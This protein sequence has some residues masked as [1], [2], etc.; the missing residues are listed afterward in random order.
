M[1]EQELIVLV[2]ELRALPKEN[3]WIEFK[4][5]KATTNE[6]LGHYLSG[7]SN[8]ASI[9]NESFGYLVFGI[10]DETHSVIGTNFKFKSS[11]E[12]NE[13]LELWIRRNLNPS[14]KFDHFSFEYTG[15]HL[16]L[17]RIPAAIGEPTT[18]KNQ[19]FIRIGTNLTDMRKFPD[20]IRTI[21]NSQI[22]WSAQTI[23]TATIEDLDTN[24]IQLARTKYK[25]KNTNA[26]FFN[27]I[28]NWS[29][30][31]FLDKLKITINGKITNT[32]I[33]LLGKP[34]SAHFISPAVGQIT[35]KLDTQEQAYEHFNMPLFSE[36]NSILTKIRNVKYKFF[37]DNQLLATEVNKYDT[38]VILEALN[39]C[40][41]HQD[42]SKHSRIL[43]T[44]QINKLIFSNAG[45]FFDGNVEDYTAGDKTPKKYRNKWLAEAM[46][47]L[48]MIDTL[49]Y[50]I[51][52][53]YNE[54]RRRYFPLPDYTK[55]DRDNVVLEIYGHSIDENYSKLLI[56]KKD[57]L[58]LTEVILLDKIQKKQSITDEGAKLLK[59]KGL[60]EGRKPN[61]YI[62]A[63][64]AEMTGQKASYTKNKGFDK[65]YYQDLIVKHIKNHNYA[66]RIE[67]DEL[68]F[69]ILPDHKNEKQRKIYINNIISEMAGTLIEN[70]GSR[71]KSKWILLKK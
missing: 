7:I 50:G 45:S 43:L 42:Y 64:L 5:G 49:G 66:S 9:S 54:Q 40:I 10:E 60:I 55:S 56:E 19:P 20:H 27:E 48:T 12:G 53:M 63:K 11:K 46:V 51:H 4:T 31:V 26:S 24:S 2:D 34:K 16:E 18:F 22:D 23:D 41:A 69:N 8:A 61:Y 52:R 70:I 15:L 28:D 6:R 39:N 71:T 25:E 62:S 44:E 3:E 14:I 30:A 59:S 65:E 35:W 68:L 17:F 37:P 58:S 13:E 29:D 67:I 57:D 21:Y 32:A 33:L 36:I 38:K 1:T 47:N